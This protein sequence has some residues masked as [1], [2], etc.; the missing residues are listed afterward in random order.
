MPLVSIVL[1]TYQR[2]A[3]LRSA[4][5][6]I[7][8]QTLT[9][10]E[11]LIV[12]DAST[13]PISPNFDDPRIQVIRNESNLRLPRSLNRGF[14]QAKGKYLT[15]TSDD[16]WYRPCALQSMAQ[17]LE[18]NPAVDLIY[19]GASIVSAQR[20]FIR[21]WPALQVEDQPILP[22]CG[23]C[24]LYRRELADRV[25][26]YRATAFLAEDL[27]FWIRARIAGE[28]LALNEDLYEYREHAESL[29]STRRDEARQQSARVVEEH[30]P[31]ISWFTRR[32]RGQTALGLAEAAY[33]RRDIGALRH[34]TRIAIWG[35]P[36]KVF[37]D[38]KRGLLAAIGLIR[39]G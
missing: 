32:T 16:N 10:W 4:V 7:L 25:G 17:A 26:E 31:N 12:D 24:F 22:W 39:L 36:D 15:W 21:S 2:P 13:P 27:D 19:A 29:S 35:C 11:L 20:E 1:P 28:F 34:W 8:A 18:A 33:R 30:W 5:A 6:S 37:M 9:D 14:S 3:D 38:F 23:A